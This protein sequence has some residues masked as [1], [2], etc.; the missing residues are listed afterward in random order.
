LLYDLSTGLCS[1]AFAG[2][3][4]PLFFT[5]LS[6]MVCD[7]Y[8]YIYALLQAE[9]AALPDFISFLALKLFPRFKM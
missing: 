9:D 6:N 5:C 7:G 1:P 8:I 2:G 4:V 3:K